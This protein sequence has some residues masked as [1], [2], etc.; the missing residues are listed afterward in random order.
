MALTI[1]TGFVVDDAIVMI[2]NIARYI[3]AGRAAVRGGA[4]GREADRLHHRL[5][6]RVAGGGADPAAVHGRRHRA[7]V[8]RVRGHAQH[9]DRRL[10]GALADADRD[11]VRAHAAA[12]TRERARARRARVRA[13][14]RLAWSRFY[15]RGLEW[16]LDH[17]RADAG[18]HASATVALTVRAGGRRPEGLLPAAGHRPHL[19]R[20]RGAA[21]R[22]VRAH[23]GRCSARSPTCVPRRS[24]RRDGRRR[25]SA[26]TA[27]T[28]RVNSGRL[29]IAL[30][31]RDAARRR[32]RTRSSTACSA[33]ARARCSGITVYLQAVQD[34]QI[35]SR[36]S[37]TQYQYTLED[38]DPEELATWA[39]R[40][41]ERAAR[42][43]PSWRDVASDQQDGGLQLTLVIDRD[44]ASRLGITAAGDRRHALR[45]LRPAPGLDD[46]HPAQPVPRHPRGRSPSSSRTRDAL[47]QHLRARRQPAS[48]CRSS[49][50]A[51][52]ERSQPRRSS[53]SHQGQFPAVTLS[54]NL[55]PRR[56]RW[57]T[58]STPIRRGDGRARRCRPACARDFQGAAP[59][60]GESLASEPLLILAALV[61]VY[62]VLGVLYE[63]YIHPITILSTLP[64]AGVGAL[65]ALMLCRHRVQRHRAHR[66]HPAHRH[67]EE[68]RH[69]DDRLRARGR[70][71]AGHVARARRSTR[72]ACCASG[73]IMM[74]TMAALLGGLPLALGTRHRRRAAPP[75]RHRHRRRP[76]ASRRC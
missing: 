25:S 46:L 60:F 17:Q 37:R 14:L 43:C 36:V 68:E 56:R 9:R 47:D 29:S 55:A 24:R 19:G 5:A 26:P 38:A 58:R 52:Y 65:L 7:A 4:Q 21:R 16:V 42:S 39:P 48:R 23:D 54:F 44:T 74:T 59:A 22:L 28:P 62:I 61:T 57:A 31:P 10:G 50:F 63:S 73:P 49:T 15:D 67:R 6:H 69:H 71:R 11:D 75:A 3:E 66:H 70:A 51:R 1:S 2:E 30:K 40:V 76:A 13:R 34:L 41:L 64:S 33:Q 20:D 32:R 35:E 72:R 12:R 45:R 18:R 8:P 53:I 27:P